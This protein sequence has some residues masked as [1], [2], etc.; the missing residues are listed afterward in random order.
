MKILYIELENFI[1]IRAAMNVTFVR[2]DF[3]SINKP[4]IQIYG[5]NHCGKTVLAHLLH[6][7]ANINF[8]GDERND[9]SLIVP[10]ET[11]IKKIGYESDGHIYDITHTYTPTKTSHSISSSILKDGE[12]LNPTKGVNTF[13]TIIDHELSINKYIFQFIINGTQLTNMGTM[14]DTQRKNAM[15]KAMGIDIYN[16]IHKMSTDDYRYTNKIITALSNSREFLL[17]EYGTY[18]NLCVRLDMKKTQHASLSETAEKRKS[19]MSE[20]DGKISTL[21]SQ[22][23]Y[24]ELSILNNQIMSYDNVLSQLGE[25]SATMGDDLVNEQIELNQKISDAKSIRFGLVKDRDILFGKREDIQ[26][27]IR[28]DQKAINDYQE[29]K[30]MKEDLTNQITNMPTYT[31]QTAPSYLTNMLN[32][33]MVVNSTC[34]E[35][36]MCLNDNLLN[37]MCDM[38]INDIS[39]EN[40]LIREGA[41]LKDNESEKAAVHRLHSILN[42]V[43]GDIVSCDKK[44]L[45]KNSYDMMQKFFST[46]QSTD[47]SSYTAYDIEQLEIAYKG[48]Q[49]IKRVIS[50]QIADECK[51][52]FNI[53]TIATNIKNR[54]YGIDVDY[55]NELIDHATTEETRLRLIKQV[56]DIDRNLENMNNLLFKNGEVNEQEAIEAINKEIDNINGQIA[57]CDQDIAEAESLTETNKN[58]RILHASIRN[59]NIGDVR[60]RFSKMSKLADELRQYESEYATIS[61][62]YYQVNSELQMVATDLKKLEDAYNQYANNVAEIEKHME[63][64]KRYKIISEAT[65]STKGK[66][67]LSIREKVMSALSMTNRLL[68]VMYDGDMEMLKPVIDESTFSLPFRSGTN[69]LSDI[70]YGSQSENTLLSLAFDLSIALSL[71]EYN[72][73]IIDELDAFLDA[74][75]S[76]SFITM[77]NEIMNT[78]RMEQLFIISHKVQPGQY[79]QFV[80]TF[81]LID[82][83]N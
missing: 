33:A 15:Y 68:D 34:R 37:T 82:E 66:P 50:V 43:A 8:T 6:P 72:I 71:T 17:A 55:I 3:S 74:E 56:A 44:C 61:G 10:G 25:V 14:S 81:N 23:I 42:G 80:H 20:L 1:G 2:F 30:Q 63:K 11:G 51:D 60:M 45:Y 35:V 49:S 19:R 78:L 32:L 39:V 79:D 76:D 52:L 65:S 21:K 83:L 31:I 27:T 29:L 47:P 46:Y 40:F 9:L 24:E 36:I 12:E 41:T 22:N 26:N 59:I 53:K 13:N 67:V 64:D 7:F 69:K 18:E 77:I 62:E 4:I 48:I 58:K 73:P 5:P 54:E 38:I 57:K 70:R 28:M 75:V 16:A